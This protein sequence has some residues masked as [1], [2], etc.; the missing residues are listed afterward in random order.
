MPMY[1]GKFGAPVMMKSSRSQPV[2]SA[3]GDKPAVAMSAT[4]TMTAR[5]NFFISRTP[6]KALQERKT[7]NSLPDSTRSQLTY[8][9]D[10]AKRFR[11]GKCAADERIGV[12]ALSQPEHKQ[13]V[14]N[15]PQ[16]HDAQDEQQRQLAA[17]DASA[18]VAGVTRGADVA[19]L[20]S[21]QPNRRD[22]A[23]TFRARHVHRMLHMLRLL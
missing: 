16:Q 10:V 15:Q 1:C 9:H 12:P 6:K 18:G 21:H 22:R 11:P 4:I 14:Q 2:A 5:R 13:P 7:T 17:G 19:L 23:V 3:R 20:V 8:S